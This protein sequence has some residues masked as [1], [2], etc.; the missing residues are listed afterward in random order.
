MIVLVLLILG[1]TPIAAQPWKICGDPTM[2]YTTNSTYHANLEHLSTMLTDNA[3][4]NRYHYATGHVGTAPD[5]VYGLALCRGDV[6]ATACHACIATASL[7][8]QQLCPYRA[9]A[10]VFYP[11]CRLRFSGKNFLHPNNYSLIL[12]GVVNTMNTTDTT[13]TEPV[14]PNWDP[15]NSEAVADITGIIKKLLQETASHAAYNSGAR[16]FATGRMDVRGGFP[17]LF[18]MAQCVPALS[19]RDCWS[20]LQVISYM[21]TD[22]FAGR[23]GGRL[24]ALWCNLRYD[25]VQFY[26]DDPMVTI[27][28]PVKEV[29]TPVALLVVP[30]QKHKSK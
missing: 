8:A 28:S 21:A 1:F 9:D 18:S 26:G 4:A 7:G 17:P 30:N 15:S 3:T 19:H 14:L 29:V 25:T 11:T 27:M 13:N 10:T 12:D 5:I 22:N 16:M 6:N 23:Q 2:N 20:C 24:L